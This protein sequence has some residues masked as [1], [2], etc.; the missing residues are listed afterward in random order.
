[1]YL[2]LL[3]SLKGFIPFCDLLK[4]MYGISIVESPD[5][6][7][8]FAVIFGRWLFLVCRKIWSIVSE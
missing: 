3:H 5:A 2:Q 6:V 1:M 8:Q 4:V 7:H